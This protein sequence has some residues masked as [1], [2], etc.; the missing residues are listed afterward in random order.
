MNE[1]LN[2]KRVN[3]NLLVSLLYLDTKTANKD[4]FSASFVHLRNKSMLITLLKFCLLKPGTVQIVKINGRVV[5]CFV[6]PSTTTVAD[7]IALLY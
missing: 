5:S 1:I 4:A 7:C 3:G 6:T 2:T